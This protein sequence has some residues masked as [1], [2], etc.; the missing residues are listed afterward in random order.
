M[1]RKYNCTLIE[2]KVDLS[3][4]VTALVLHIKNSELEKGKKKE[5]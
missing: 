4:I 1:K 3:A 2:R 5:D